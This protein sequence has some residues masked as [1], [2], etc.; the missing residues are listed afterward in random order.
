MHV[1]S[2][3]MCGVSKVDLD[4]FV[5]SLNANLPW[6][7]VCIQEG[8]RNVTAGTFSFHNHWRVQCS[9]GM[10]GSTMVLL[11]PRLGQRVRRTCQGADYSIVE[12]AVSP[13]LLVASWH[14]PSNSA[15]PD[16]Y[17]ASLN[18][19]Q[20]DIEYLTGNNHRVSV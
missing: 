13:P 10:R 3:N 15:G 18:T 16:A 7:V 19:L 14:A 8:L 17:Q 5:D 20:A 9:S 11:H 12:L 6:D 4:D 2:W 1:F